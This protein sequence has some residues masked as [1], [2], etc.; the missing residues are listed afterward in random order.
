MLFSVGIFEISLI[1]RLFNSMRPYY[2]GR[3]LRLLVINTSLAYFHNG[4]TGT[5]RTIFIMYLPATYSQTIKCKQHL[6][7][8]NTNFKESI[9]FTT[10]SNVCATTSKYPL[11]QYGMFIPL[12]LISQ[13]V[14]SIPKKLYLY[15]YSYLYGFLRFS[16]K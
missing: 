7:L 9:E 14:L 6:T 8:H 1:T 12:I 3:Y 16:Y 15:L 11:V 2:V 10:F 5:Y 4:L 13:K